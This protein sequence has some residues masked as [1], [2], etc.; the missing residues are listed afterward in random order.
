M[1]RGRR[2]S[3]PDIRRYRRI[4][5]Q[6]IHGITSGS[7]DLSHDADNEISLLSAFPE[8][9]VGM[10]F[11]IHLRKLGST[12][13]RGI[14]RPLPGLQQAFRHDAV[15]AWLHFNQASLTGKSAYADSA[16]RRPL[17]S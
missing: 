4:D 5:K 16:A 11:V 2:L 10:A 6:N 15:S 9:A 14:S 8:N 13:G 3:I 12:C 17:P 1:A 7:V